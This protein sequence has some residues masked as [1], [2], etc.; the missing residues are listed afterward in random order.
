MIKKIKV[1]PDKVGADIFF[2]QEIDLMALPNPRIVPLF[3]PNGVGKSTLINGI[4]QYFEAVKYLQRKNENK[5]DTILDVLNPDYKFVNHLDRIGLTLEYDKEKFS[6]YSYRNSEDNF[7]NRKV[8][9]VNES[10]DPA[11]LVYRMNAQ[12]VSEG[13]S[14]VYSAFDLLDGLKPGKKMF[15]DTDSALLVLLDE[16]DS[17]MSID[18]IDIAMRKLKKAVTAREK[19]QVFLSFNSPRVLKHFPYVISMY[20]G[21]VKEMHTD[22]DMMAEIQVN[23]KLFDKARKKSNG[24][25]KIFQ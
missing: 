1:N 25:P 7:R 6:L 3:G 4:Q 15:G 22:D 14:I 13:Q 9:S 10:F 8:R 20:D 16:L 12:S 2:F 23:S 17:G 19:I 18:N 24:R 11:Y 5:V 21:K